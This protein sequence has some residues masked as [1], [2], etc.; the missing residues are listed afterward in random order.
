M[1]SFLS[2]INALSVIVVGEKGGGDWLF[3][4]SGQSEGLCPLSRNIMS[5]FS[6]VY[7][8]Y[9]QGYMISLKIADQV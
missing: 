6:R 5:Y 4:L 9:S 1:A 3:K 8:F 2:E 7:D